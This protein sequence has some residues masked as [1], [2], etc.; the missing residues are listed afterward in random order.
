M[1]TI[2]QRP[3]VDR[4]VNVPDKFEMKEKM[5]TKEGEEEYAKHHSN[6]VMQGMKEDQEKHK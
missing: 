2:Q 1:E 6:W 5:R 4:G 3:A